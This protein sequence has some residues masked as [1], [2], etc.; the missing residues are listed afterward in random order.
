MRSDHIT[1]VKLCLLCTKHSF[2]LVW[3]VHWSAFYINLLKPSFL[4]KFI[5][6][7]PSDSSLSVVTKLMPVCFIYPDY[8]MSRI[9]IPSTSSTHFYVSS[10]CEVSWYG[11]KCLALKFSGHYKYSFNLISSFYVMPI[12]PPSSKDLIDKAYFKDLTILFIA[13]PDSLIFCKF[14]MTNE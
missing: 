13:I 2:P 5:D 7:A 12:L 14:T 3:I 8:T 1:T 6:I 4:E 9:L 10:S 11:A